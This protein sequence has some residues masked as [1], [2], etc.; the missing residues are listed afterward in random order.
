M[1]CLELALQAPTAGDTQGWQWVLVRDAAKKRALADI[2]R[3]NLAG[4]QHLSPEKPPHAA[5]RGARSERFAASGQHLVKHMQDAPVLLIPC[6]RGRVESGSGG[7]G[8]TFWASLMP[9]AWS[10]CLALRSRG[11]GTC[12]ATLHLLGEGE[13][14][15]AEVLGIPY[16][17]YSQ[18]GMFPIAYTKGTNFNRANRVPA[19]HVSHFDAW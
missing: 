5:D 11:L 10:F 9:A 3:G 15:A 14:R 8:A 7:A 16:S 6:L 2:Y 1:E 18:A 17:E 19:E 13:Q 12:W 4:Y